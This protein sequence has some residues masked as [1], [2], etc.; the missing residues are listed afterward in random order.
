M[1]KRPTKHEKSVARAKR[2]VGRPRDDRVRKA[3]LASTIRLLEKKGSMKAMTTDE[4]AAAAGASKAT[5]YHWWPTK[6]AVV[7]DSFLETVASE[8]QFPPKGSGPERIKEQM[9]RLVR[10]YAGKHGRVLRVII[11]EAQ[12]DPET[13]K[14]LLNGYIL[15]RRDD[16]KA[17]IA[18]AVAAGDLRS[19][20]DSEVMIEAL[21]GAVF[22]TLLLSH[23][24]LDDRWIQEIANAVLYGLIQRSK[25]SAVNNS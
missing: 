17:V 15:R 24:P 22:Y 14:A 10:A 8:I 1:T 6:A 23:R 13:L 20:I 3:I 4:I 7:I 18:E 16:A 25:S 9:R 21:Y 5:I 2:G 12:S 11:A 19:D